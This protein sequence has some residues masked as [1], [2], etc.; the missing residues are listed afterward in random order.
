MSKNPCTVGKPVWAETVVPAW[1]PLVWQQGVFGAW[2]DV[3]FFI[4]YGRA[5]Q[6]VLLLSFFV[7]SCT[8]PRLLSHD[9]LLYKE[10][11]SGCFLRFYLAVV[12]L[13]CTFFNS[14]RLKCHCSQFCGV[15]TLLR[16]FTSVLM[17]YL[18]WHILHYACVRWLREALHDQS[19]SRAN[20]PYRTQAVI[21]YFVPSL[22]EI[23]NKM[24]LF[25]ITEIVTQG[26]MI[27]YVM[28]MAD[29]IS[30]DNS[31]FFHFVLVFS[32]VLVGRYIF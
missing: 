10:M 8:L 6:T 14:V 5:L 23:M 18:C 30:S 21:L 27:K 20:S 9:P 32:L 28:I 16:L 1:I 25:V 4:M 19:S 31:F 12:G 29:Y 2:R 7:P 24:N 22:F 11:S 3:F 15:K 17:F 13:G 26:R